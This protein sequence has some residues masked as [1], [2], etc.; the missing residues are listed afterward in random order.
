[1]KIRREPRGLHLYNRNRNN[2]IHLLFDESPLASGTEHKG[3]TVLSIALTNACDLTCSFCYAPKSTHSLDPELV[4][5]WCREVASHGTLEVAFGGGEPTLYKNLPE[6]CR[7]IW[8]ET[9]LGI[10]VTSHGQH[11]DKN[12]VEALKGYVSVL[13]IS[14]DAPEPAYSSIRRRPLQLVI[15]NIRRAI[16]RIPIGINTVVNSMTLETL[17]TL[18]EI[19][20]AIG[21]VDWLL[22]P[23]T[24]NGI[25]SMTAAEMNRLSKWI[26]G[27]SSTLN[28]LTSAIS[29]SALA[30]P[31]LF[32]EC[33]REYA[34]VRAD[35]FLCKTSYA[36]IGVPIDRSIMDAYQLLG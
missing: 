9:D 8:A 6:L 11:L 21:P 24:R 13:R 23:E 25:H 17:D 7:S 12:L 35:K 10:S 29:T 31:V 30:V 33:P 34:H 2:G 28:I 27:N 14:I 19:V 20:A 26:L 36:E 18:A 32:P 3:P 15:E 1:M 22:L 5:E 4:L 16:D